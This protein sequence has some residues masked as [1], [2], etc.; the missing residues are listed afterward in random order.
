MFAAVLRQLND[1]LREEVYDAGMLGCHN[2]VC[3]AALAGDNMASCSTPVPCSEQDKSERIF[4]RQLAYA[5]DGH[6]S[7]LDIE[8]HE[9]HTLTPDTVRHARQ[10]IYSL[11]ATCQYGTGTAEDTVSHCRL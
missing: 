8:C 1:A 3:Q 11:I 10:Y 4:C 5:R 2:I 6:Q 7:T 9:M